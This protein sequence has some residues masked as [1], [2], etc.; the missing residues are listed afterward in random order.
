MIVLTPENVAPQTLAF[1]PTVEV[2]TVTDIRIID[3]ET[4]VAVDID[5][6]QEIDDEEAT[7]FL[8]DYY[9]SLTRIWDIKE[10]RRY[11]LKIY[12]TGTLLFVGKILCTSQNVVTF[13]ISNGQYTSNATLNEF[14]TY[15]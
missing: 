5:F 9:T 7:Y 6:T 8:G 3:E 13:K 12:D 14:I 11:I 2:V 4:N 15:E 1:I 10:G